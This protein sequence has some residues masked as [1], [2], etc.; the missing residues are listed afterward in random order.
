MR[1]FFPNIIGRVNEKLEQ[2]KELSADVRPYELPEQ[3]VLLQ[4]RGGGGLVHHT[5]GPS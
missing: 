5:A 2:K 1:E 3:S 4:E